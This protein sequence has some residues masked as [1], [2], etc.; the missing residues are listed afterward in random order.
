MGERVESLGNGAVSVHLVRGRGELLVGELELWEFLWVPDL[1][2][3]HEGE[4]RA[5]SLNEGVSATW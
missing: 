2:V 3:V 4:G 1:I 5:H